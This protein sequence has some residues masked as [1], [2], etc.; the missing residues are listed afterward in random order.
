MKIGDIAARQLTPPIEPQATPSQ[1]GMPMQETLS[2][3]R[4]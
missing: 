3:Q 1:R 4:S 2:T